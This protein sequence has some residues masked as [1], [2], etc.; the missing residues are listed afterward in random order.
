MA[1]LVGLLHKSDIYLIFDRYYADSIKNGTRP[2]RAGKEASRRHKLN[3][4]TPLP[5]QKVA[6][7]VTENKVQ[8]INLAVKYIKDNLEMFQMTY[9]GLDGIQSVHV[10]SDDT[11]VMA[12]LLHFYA[13][14]ELSCNLLIVGTSVKQTRCP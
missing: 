5:S 2:A 8:L 4:N 13:L 7:T 1:Y 10:I 9:L 3:L 12:L 11:D 6:L 14:K